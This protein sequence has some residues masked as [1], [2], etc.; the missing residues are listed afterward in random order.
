MGDFYDKVGN[1]CVAG[2]SDGVRFGDNGIEGDEG[3]VAAIV[4]KHDVVIDGLARRALVPI[5]E[6]IQ[7][8]NGRWRRGCDDDA[9]SLTWDARMLKTYGLSVPPPI[10]DFAANTID[11]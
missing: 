3:A 11:S 5:I 7:R 8:E 4:K 2:W 1:A 10:S 6:Y 9:P